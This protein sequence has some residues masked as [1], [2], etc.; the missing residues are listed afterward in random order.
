M[1]VLVDTTVWSTAFRRRAGTRSSEQEG[2]VA[3]L[4]ELVREMRA[5][6]I[7]PIRQEILSGIPDERQFRRLRDTLRA[8]PDLSL[9]SEDYETAAE[10][11]TR[12]RRRGVQ[13]THI[14]FLICGAAA[15]RD[16]A[17]FTLD[18]DFGRYAKLLR[19]KLHTPR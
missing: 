13:G 3:E 9:E 1:N 19:L 18:K 16:L 8:F 7:G 12:C 10:F 2:V 4:R 6:I 14:D 11:Y 17:I 15:Q 5:E